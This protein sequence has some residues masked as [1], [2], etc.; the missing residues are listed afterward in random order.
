MFVRCFLSIERGP[1]IYQKRLISF[2]QVKNSN[3]NGKAKNGMSLIRWFIYWLLSF[4]NQSTPYYMQPIWSFWSDWKWINPIS[5]G[6]TDNNGDENNK[7]YRT[8]YTRDDTERV[9]RQF[10]HDSFSAVFWSFFS[11]LHYTFSPYKTI[12]AIL[13]FIKIKRTPRCRRT[14]RWTL[15]CYLNG[16][17]QISILIVH[18]ITAYVSVWVSTCSRCFRS[19]HD[20]EVNRGKRTDPIYCIESG[21][22]KATSCV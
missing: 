13:I 6:S 15:F 12:Y 8:Q 4:T 17:V 19:T 3:R 22:I 7:S 16:R 18:Q 5:I 10:I 2:V 1:V 11:C 9:K 14:E 20:T 21:E